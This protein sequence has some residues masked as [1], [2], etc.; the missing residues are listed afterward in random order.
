MTQDKP[1]FTSPEP[2]EVTSVPLSNLERI[3]QPLSGDRLEAFASRLNRGW[4]AVRRQPPDAKVTTTV[5]PVA[6]QY[7][8]ERAEVEM[9]LADDLY[10]WIGET[11][12][13]H[14]NNSPRQYADA[15]VHEFLNVPCSDEDL[16][17]FLRAFAAAYE[18]MIRNRLEITNSPLFSE[19]PTDR[20]TIGM[21]SVQRKRMTIRM[22]RLT[23]LHQNNPDGADLFRLSEFAGCTAD[24]LAR[25]LNQPSDEVQQQIDDRW[26]DICDS[27]TEI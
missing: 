26:Y 22:S 20:T 10:L 15:A 16:L 21:V 24:E 23:A 2:P 12:D 9:E 27:T 17:E 6:P 13:T 3:S 14:I 18:R 1:Q 25:Y 7:P 4:N 5:S 19:Q 11:L 8:L